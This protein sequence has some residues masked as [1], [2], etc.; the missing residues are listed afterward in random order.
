[1]KTPAALASALVAL[2]SASAAERPN[3][4]IIY[5]DDVGYGDIACYGSASFETPHIDALAAE[6]LRFTDAHCTAATCTPSRFTLL[7]GSYAFR[8]QRAK[9]LPGSAPLIIDPAMDTLPKVLQGGGYKTAVVGKWHLGLG[10]GDV[11]WNGEVKPGPREVGFDYHFLIPATGDRTPCVYLEQGRVVGLDPADPI[12]VSYGKRIGDA[13]SGAEARD[14]LKQD[15]SHGHNSTIVNGIS[16]I[17]WMTGGEAAR[18]VDEDM[19]DVITERAVN[20]IEENRA[21]PFFLF[22]S[23]HDIHVPRVPHARFVGKSGTGPRGDAMVQTDW[24]VGELMAALEKHGLKEKTLVI[25]SS[26]NGPVL[27]DGY[28]DDANEKLGE[29]D[30]N[31]ALRAGKYSHF[32]GGTRVPFIVRWPGEVAP[33]GVSGALFGQVDLARTLCGIAGVEVPEAAFVDSRDAR[34]AL[35]DPDAGGRPHL[36]HEAGKLALRLGQWKFVPGGGTRDELGPWKK[37]A[38]GKEGALYDLAVDLGERRD[39]AAEKPEKLAEMK[40]LLEKIKAGADG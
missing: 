5:T 1:M 13:P 4:V 40:A 16:R 31:G 30:P 17:G 9:I 33:G 15:W 12:A 27:D 28:K 35:V 7:T 10:E 29:H 18:W 37:A 21:E 36:V 8:N 19:A 25:F 39:L 26:D 32:E 20:F 23:T 22:Y 6:G 11:D 34:A 3:I 38:T 24:C 14:T 2:A